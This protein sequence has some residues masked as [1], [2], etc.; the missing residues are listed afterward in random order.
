MPAVFMQRDAV[1]AAHE[2]RYTSFVL[3]RSVVT[4]GLCSALLL[5]ASRPC[6]ADEPEPSREASRLG[7]DGRT[8]PIPGL[9]AGGSALALVGAAGVVVSSLVLLQAPSDDS[10]V[11]AGGVGFGAGFV[12]MGLGTG[13]VIYGAPRRVSTAHEPTPVQRGLATGASVRWCF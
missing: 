12:A 11:A 8:R 1:R 4:A 7:P 10:T 13:M 9:I 2:E 6:S 5:L 3:Q